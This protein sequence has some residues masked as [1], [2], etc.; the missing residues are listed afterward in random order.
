M[1]KV[2]IDTGIIACTSN[3]VIHD[4][5]IMSESRIQLLILLNRKSKSYKTVCFQ[6][7]NSWPWNRKRF[8]SRSI[9]KK[10][11]KTNF[12]WFSHRWK[13]LIN[14]NSK[15]S[16]REVFFTKY[17]VILWQGIFHSI[18]F[19]HLFEKSMHCYKNILSR[20]HNCLSI[21]AWKITGSCL[22][23]VRVLSDIDGCLVIYHNSL[24]FV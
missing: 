24:K 8:Y 1:F 20:K 6:R 18:T 15:K 4:L 21:N 3:Y 2:R 22:F 7:W 10:R 11:Q 16:K 23:S 17:P 12:C 9:I 14:L 5:K 19:R 13:E